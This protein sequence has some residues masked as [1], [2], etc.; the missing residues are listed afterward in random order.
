MT[1]L[2]RYNDDARNELMKMVQ[3]HARQLGEHCATVQI[4]VTVELESGN[5]YRTYEFGIGNIF[6]RM[7]HVREWCLI[8][9][10]KARE[11]ARKDSSQK[12]N[13]D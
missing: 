8:Q 7:G 12:E 13:E 11:L 1:D 10:E 9:D 2:G 6:A 5:E 4:L 3:E